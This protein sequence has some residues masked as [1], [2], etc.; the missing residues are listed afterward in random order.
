MQCK[1][2][3][4]FHLHSKVRMRCNLVFDSEGVLV[5]HQL[6]KFH[7]LYF[8]LT[9]DLHSEEELG[10]LRTLFLFHAKHQRHCWLKIMQ[11]HA[12]GGYSNRHH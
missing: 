6:H 2:I 4:G 7:L 8:R 9:A 3:L 12:Q 1:G 5:H 10:T 11:E